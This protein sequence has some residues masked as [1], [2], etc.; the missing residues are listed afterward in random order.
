[1]SIRY[2]KFKPKK[3]AVSIGGALAIMLS[4][5]VHAEIKDVD[6]KIDS[7]S[8]GKAILDLAEQTGSQIAFPSALNT[9]LILPEI[10]GQYTVTE[11]LDF[12]LQG[13]GLVYQVLSDSSIVV[14]EGEKEASTSE[15]K[16]EEPVEEIVIT[17]SRLI[18]DP[19]KLT[20][21]ITVFDRSEIERSG[22]TRLDEFLNRLPQN[23]NAPNNI[24]SGFQMGSSAPT[25]FGVGANVFAGSSIN[26]RGMGSQYTLI[27]VDGR[28]PPSGGQY[29]DITDISNIPIER[30]DRIEILFDGAAAIYGAD[31]VGGVVNIITNRSYS[32]TNV[33]LTYGDTT[34]GGGARTNLS[35]GHTFNWGSGSATATVGMQ[36][37]EQIDGASRDSRLADTLAYSLPPSSPG[38]VSGRGVVNYR[39]TDLPLFWVKDVDG[40]GDT[41][42]Q[43]LNER[44][45]GGVEIAVLERRAAWIN[46]VPNYEY[47]ETTAIVDRRNPVLPSTQTALDPLPT[48]PSLD[49]YRPVMAAQIPEGA[50]SG[51]TIYDFSDSEELGES[52]YIPF[53]GMALTPEDKTHY[54]SL[55]LDQDI[56][57]DLKLALSLNYSKTE[58][59]SNTSGNT[60]LYSVAASASNP[61]VQG[62]TYSFT[63]AF[64]QQFQLVDQSSMGVSG[65]LL[66]DINDTWRSNLGFSVSK[67]KNRSQSVNQIRSR[68]TS[69]A[70]SLE[71]IEPNLGDLLNGYSYYY[72]EN[73]VRHNVD[74]GVS[75]LDPNLGYD[76]PQALAAALADPDLL[77][78]NNSTNRE[79]DLNVQ[80]T[81][82]ET[83]AG[84]ATTN[85][86]LS[87]RVTEN[88]LFNS[89][90]FYSNDGLLDGNGFG[91]IITKYDVE[92]ELSTNSV[93]A[94]LAVPTVSEDMAVPFVKGLLFNASARYEDYS[95]TE[96]S[97]LNWQLGMNWEVNDWMTVRLNRTYNLVVP[98]AMKSALPESFYRTS[99]KLWGDPDDF[100]TRYTHSS[101][102]W[103]LN[104]GTDNLKPETNYGTA[105]GFIFTPTFVDGLRIQLNLTES[106]TQDLISANGMGDPGAIGRWTADYISPENIALNPALSIADPENNPDH[107]LFYY[108]S[109]GTL[110]EVAP[111]DIIWDNRAVNTGMLYNRG[112]DLEVSYHLSNTWGDWYLSWRHQYLDANE[113]TNSS[114]CQGGVCDTTQELDGMA[115][116][117]V[118]TVDRYHTQKFALPE[119]SGSVDLSWGYDGLTVSLFT[120]YQEETSILKFREWSRIDNVVYYNY[121][122]ETTSPAKSVDMTASYDFSHGKG[123]PSMFESMK[124]SL[125]VAGVWRSDRKFKREYVSQEFTP[126]ANPRGELNRSSY[127]ARGRA[128]TLRVSSSF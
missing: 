102:L 108:T 98:D 30:V 66:W 21:Q 17:G 112:A 65:N 18:T 78:V 43:S 28:R 125:S 36:S 59:I 123:L 9:K 94:E 38:N 107:R 1:M 3:I 64:P 115:V 105:L 91:Q 96:E 47:V 41:L 114:I 8:A 32:G 113:V 128:F 121:P 71:E 83:S 39:V 42:N 20:R 26:L 44:L 55:D 12:M 70:R 15:S 54:A 69:T 99:L 120:R 103:T 16:K 72:D 116:D 62:L 27:L 122:R 74:L 34:E 82:F 127:N 73:F 50:G 58:K 97:G 118:D 81:L 85:I 49:G 2:N 100:A 14:K 13:T 40:N 22:A 33:S 10:Q 111:G 93:A 104:G 92:T 75:F 5:A 76:S 25:D 80:G 110:I 4:A 101:P 124:V 90:K 46:G 67:G 23:V 7:K 61:F 57:E 11:A 51:T 60:N 19:G 48:D 53:Q 106:E 37:Q 63:N 45:T 24:G 117:T 52:E 6:L 87:H 119:H 84:S 35:I 126:E 56:N 86:F 95:T 89:N 79:V 109:T 77:T 29:G 88:S 68:Q 31:A